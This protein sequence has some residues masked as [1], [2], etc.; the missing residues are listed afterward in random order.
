M[1]FL[2]ALFGSPARNEQVQ[3]FNPQ[4]QSALNQILG[5]ATQGLPNLNKGFDF[6]PIENQARTGFATQTVPTIAE[7]FTSMGGG[8]SSS[9]FAGALG[10][11]GSELERSLASLKSDV[12]LQQQGQQQNLLLSLL[13]QGL[14]PQAENLYHTAQPGA[15]QSA[16]SPAIQALI[17][18]LSGGAASG[19]GSA[20]SGGLGASGLNG[21]RSLGA[22]GL[23]STGFGQQPTYGTGFANPSLYSPG[24]QNL[25]RS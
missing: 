3:R 6:G 14:Q 16:L 13:Q 2:E 19:L 15:F 25:L 20:I 7:R 11:A 10:S 23:G 8:Q 12:G 17:S 24:L 18:Y 9:A 4:Q 1:A 5:Q 21:S 22:G